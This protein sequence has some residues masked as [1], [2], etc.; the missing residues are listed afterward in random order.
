[1]QHHRHRPD[2]FNNL[3]NLLKSR[4]FQWKLYLKEPLKHLKFYCVESLYFNIYSLCPQAQNRDVP[5]AAV[6]MCAA[7]RPVIHRSV[8]A[9][10]LGDQRPA[11]AIPRG[12]GE[13]AGQEDGPQAGPSC[14]QQQ[15]AQQ[16]ACE[17]CELLCIFIFFLSYNLRLFS[18][19]Q[20]QH[21][22]QSKCLKL[23]IFKNF[24]L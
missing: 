13:A 24:T 11:E 2:K 12:Q 1:M 17:L 15:S 7:I 10:E 5:A 18:Y 8:R 22:I 20:L 14:D 4:F 6:R 9:A 3:Y 21:R 16:C 23:A 19:Y